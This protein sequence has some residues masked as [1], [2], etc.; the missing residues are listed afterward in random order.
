MILFHR[1]RSRLRQGDSKGLWIYW[2][3]EKIVQI[4]ETGGGYSN[5]MTCSNI[6]N[7]FNLTLSAVFSFLLFFIFDECTLWRSWSITGGNW[8]CGGGREGERTYNSGRSKKTG[9]VNAG[10]GAEKTVNNMASPD[11][12]GSGQPGCRWSSGVLY[13]K[14]WLHGNCSEEKKQEAWRVFDHHQESER[15][16]ALGLI[17]LRIYIYICLSLVIIKKSHLILILSVLSVNNKSYVRRNEKGYWV[18]MKKWVVPLFRPLGYYG[19]GRDSGGSF[20]PFRVSS[21]CYSSRWGLMVADL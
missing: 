15:F 7:L 21:G 8:G 6:C 19:K 9:G 13:P 20:D 11:D 2:L 10:F 14:C 1:C 18:W 4:Q 16:L 3:F 5:C 12:V 17:K